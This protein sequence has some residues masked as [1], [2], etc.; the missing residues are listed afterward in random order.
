MDGAT[1][2]REEDSREL[3]AI[4]RRTLFRATMAYEIISAAG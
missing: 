4:L 3:L 2:A 1:E